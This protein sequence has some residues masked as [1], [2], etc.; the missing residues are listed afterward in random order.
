[1]RRPFLVYLAAY[2]FSV[3]RTVWKWMLKILQKFLCSLLIDIY[4]QMF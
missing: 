4:K 1:M 3:Q 2:V